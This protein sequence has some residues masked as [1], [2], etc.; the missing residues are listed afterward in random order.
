MAITVRCSPVGF[1]LLC[2]SEGLQH[3]CSALSKLTAQKLLVFIEVSV[4]D[5]TQ[6]FGLEPDVRVN[7]MRVFLKLKV[8]FIISS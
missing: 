2:Q 1:K 3:E 7:V 8:H 4:P 6:A 5:R